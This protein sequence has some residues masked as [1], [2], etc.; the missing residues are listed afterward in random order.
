MSHLN[1]KFMPSLTASFP[2][3]LLKWTGVPA[4][5]PWFEFDKERAEFSVV[6]ALPVKLLESAS[7]KFFDVKIIKK[8]NLHHIGFSALILHILWFEPSLQF[9]ELRESRNHYCLRSL[10]LSKPNAPPDWR[11]Q[12]LQVSVRIS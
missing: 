1:I 5:G 11:R 8:R 7:W 12:L 6:R 3:R 10:V 2:S 9:K 4:T